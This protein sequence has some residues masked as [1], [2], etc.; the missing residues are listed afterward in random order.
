M[1]PKQTGLRDRHFFHLLHL[2]S[3]ELVIAASVTQR[4]NGH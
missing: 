3:K 4:K 1:S 2:K